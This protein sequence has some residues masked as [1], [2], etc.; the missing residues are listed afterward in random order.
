MGDPRPIVYTPE[1]LEFINAGRRKAM[2]PP[3]DRYGDFG[4]VADPRDM[5]APKP[6]VIDA[7]EGAELRQGRELEQ[8]QRTLSADEVEAQERMEEAFRGLTQE[9]AKGLLAQFQGGGAPPYDI[10]SPGEPGFA[11]AIA[12]LALDEALTDTESMA[13]IVPGFTMEGWGDNPPVMPKGGRALQ[14]V[15]GIVAE[16]FTET[17][18]M[19][20]EGVAAPP[21]DQPPAAAGYDEPTLMMALAPQSRIGPVRAE[22]AERLSA[23]QAL[24][25][26][27][28]YAQEQGLDLDANLARYQREEIESRHYE[29][30]EELTDADVAEMD[31]LEAIERRLDEGGS[32]DRDQYAGYMGFYNAY[33]TYIGENPDATAEEAVA[34]VQAELE[35]MDTILSGEAGPEYYTEHRAADAGPA[36]PWYRAFA[37]RVT[38]GQVPNLTNVQKE[39]LNTSIAERRKAFVETMPYLRREQVAQDYGGDPGDIESGMFDYGAVGTD[40]PDIE[41]VDL[42]NVWEQDIS[43]FALSEEEVLQQYNSWLEDRGLT[44]FWAIDFWDDPEKYASGYWWNRSY[45]SGAAVEGPAQ[46][47]LRSILILPNIA[48]RGVYEI[49]TGIG[50]WTG[51]SEAAERRQEE[52]EDYPELYKGHP[53]LRNIAENRGLMSDM[54]DLY[55]YTP[56]LEEYAWMAGATG[57]GGDIFIAPFDPGLSALAKGSVA[58]VRGYKTAGAL[59]RPVIG[60]AGSGGSAFVR[61]FAEGLGDTSM[62]MNAGLRRWGGGLQDPITYASRQSA[63]YLDGQQ[64]YRHARKGG[65][66]HDDALTVAQSQ[67]TKKNRFLAD[68]ERS[69]E[70]WAAK[71]IEDLLNESSGYGRLY[72]SFLDDIDDFARTPSGTKSAMPNRRTV[73]RL[74]D[75]AY[76]NNPA[77]KSFVDNLVERGAL[78]ARGGKGW[79]DEA[80]E[81]I[82]RSARQSN[83]KMMNTLLQPL[84]YKMAQHWTVSTLE[85]SKLWRRSFTKLSMVTPSLF[86]QGE[87]LLRLGKLVGEAEQV[88]YMVRLMDDAQKAGRIKHGLHPSYDPRVTRTGRASFRPK[89]GSYIELTTDQRNAMRKYLD[90]LYK[91]GLLTERERMEVLS[92]LYPDMFARRF[93]RGVISEG[94]P[95][96]R[97]QSFIS[98]DSLRRLMNAHIEDVAAANRIGVG[99]K[100]LDEATSAT[101]QALLEPVGARHLNQNFLKRFLGRGWEAVTGRGGKKWVENFPEGMPLHA[102]IELKKLQGRLAAMDVGLRRDLSELLRSPEL[103][104][105]YF[106]EEWLRVNKPTRNDCLVALSLGPKSARS[107]SAIHSSTNNLSKIMMARTEDL[108]LGI[109]DVFKQESIMASSIT[110][111]LSEAGKA[112]LAELLDDA[113]G[114]SGYMGGTGKS[115]T[116][117][118][119]IFMSE[120]GGRETKGLSSFMTVNGYEDWMR[121]MER[122]HDDLGGFI[123]NPENFNSPKVI[124][125]ADPDFNSISAGFYYMQQ[126]GR[127][128]DEAMANIYRSWGGYDA[129]LASN[130]NLGKLLEEANT[131]RWADDPEISTILKQELVSGE[132]GKAQIGDALA[133]RI[134]TMVNVRARPNLSARLP[135]SNEEDWAQIVSDIFPKLNDEQVGKVVGALLRE[136]AGQGRML[137]MGIKDSLDEMATQII[138]VNGLNRSEGNTMLEALGIM[139]NKMRPTKPAGPKLKINLKGKPKAKRKGAKVSHKQEYITNQLRQMEER[140][141]DKWARQHGGDPPDVGLARVHEEIGGMSRIDAETHLDEALGRQAD[142]Q[143]D[144]RTATIHMDPYEVPE[145]GRLDEL[146]RLVREADAEVRAAQRNLDNLDETSLGVTESA[147]QMTA[148]DNMLYTEFISTVERHIMGRT[149]KGEVSKIG[150]RIKPI[151]EI[152]QALLSLYK[153]DKTGAYVAARAVEEGIQWLQ[154]FRYSALLGARAAFHAINMFTAPQIIWGTLG[155]RAAAASINPYNLG[156]AHRIWQVGN[157]AVKARG[158][159]TVGAPDSARIAL[160]DDMGRKYTYGDIWEMAIGTGGLRSQTRLILGAGEFKHI[161]D[162][163]RFSDKYRNFIR[164]GLET[165]LPGAVGA[166]GVR[167]GVSPLTAGGAHLGGSILPVPQT[168]GGRVVGLKQ[169][170]Y[171]RF[172]ANMTEYEDQYFRLTQVIHALKRGDD[173]IMAVGAGRRALMDYGSLTGVEKFAVQRFMMFWAFFRL[174]MMNM[175]G[176]L[177]SNPKRFANIYRTTQAPQTLREKKAKVPEEVFPEE[178]FPGMPRIPNPIMPGYEFGNSFGGFNTAELDF[179]S[180]HFL[181]TRPMISYMEGADKQS[182]Y[183]FMPPVPILD[184]AVTAAEIMM[185]P[186]WDKAIQPFR[187]YVNP[188]LK[189]ILGQRSRI[190]WKKKYID[191]KDMYLFTESG[192]GDWFWNTMIKE[193][194]TR[195]PAVAGEEH[196]GGFRYTLSDEGMERYLYF[197]NV[198]GPFLT[199]PSVMGTD[200]IPLTH[201]VSGGGTGLFGKQF[202]EEGEGDVLGTLGIVRKVGTIPITAQRTRI[203][204]ELEKRLK[205]MEEDAGVIREDEATVPGLSPIQDE[206]IRKVQERQRLREE[207]R[208]R[209]RE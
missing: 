126:M 134:E 185:A 90:D 180:H 140:F 127:L 103:Q 28:E 143:S 97:D 88:K 206:R 123:R 22:R 196:Y 82:V 160:T 148:Y 26:P 154:T 64:A 92:Q 200:T 86:V 99:S 96:W 182:H 44:D 78:P 142:A 100:A 12:E 61:G 68:A 62:V 80:L 193:E 13:A 50:D 179:Y 174:N 20:P 51:Y 209:Y 175:A 107:T 91:R 201:L 170:P 3:I 198:L 65:A 166:V 192:W 121:M 56:G 40:V 33:H 132:V 77:F 15:F 141:A 89:V 41:G 176:V 53:F 74:V 152:R 55:A 8:V 122:F 128:S 17:G 197:K 116:E 21:M 205:Q 93:G 37:T 36:D 137:I 199:V 145:I 125:L 169:N 117:E 113:S 120:L 147:K 163:A 155:G 16:P 60:R 165:S 104:A 5:A 129:L 171:A 75:E 130:K 159:R 101:K 94:L 208:P 25:S 87:D 19:L 59:G 85:S 9:K 14:Y 118:E 42:G 54:Y 46:W 186:D 45:P 23:A 207:E 184:A 31:R 102:V 83:P 158:L 27:A 162:D 119:R 150:A 139:I 188:D 146:E 98:T 49:G 70:E 135:R 151:G 178:L 11:E 136:E 48:S 4:P 66:S 6:Q 95:F 39:Y 32:S 73:N 72:N 190:E 30:G 181:L 124:Q 183:T 18:E 108:V 115:I 144:L 1:D 173:P 63:H 43:A 106:D 167:A 202:G 35:L 58:G 69:G 79:T 177:L 34:A 84:N 105:R 24:K 161:L 67:F 187:D 172:L 194:P 153:V 52:D 204:Q 81:E 10:P 131:I 109:A 111:T 203:L 71:S 76:D 195:T 38:H 189:L 114:R 47:G 133:R 149:V 156:L 110:D 138:R 29:L 7:G 112:R 57:L 191:P 157:P 2:L 164:T 168:I